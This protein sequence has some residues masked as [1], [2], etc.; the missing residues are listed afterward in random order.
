MKNGP[1]YYTALILIIIWW[2]NWWLVWFFGYDLVAAIFWVMSWLS[3]IIY[4]IIGIS[5]IYI[6]I[7]AGMKE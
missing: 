1:L 2:L 3:R 5:A 6:A 7:V 4:A